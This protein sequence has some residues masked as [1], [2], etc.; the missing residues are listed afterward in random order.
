[1][2]IKKIYIIAA[3]TALFGALSKN[4]A[5]SKKLVKSE[6]IQNSAKIHFN[7]FCKMSNFSENVSHPKNPCVYTMSAENLKTVHGNLDTQFS[8]RI[9]NKEST[10]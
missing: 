2:A 8:T 5:A 1:V 3:I 9:I 4:I 7:T 6:T 10:G